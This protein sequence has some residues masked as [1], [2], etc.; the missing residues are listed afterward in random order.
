MQGAANAFKTGAVG[1]FM[2]Y[3]WNISEMKTARDQ[4]LNWG[5][6]L[7]PKSAT[8][9]KRSFYMHLECW[10][11]AK[12]S[13]VPNAAWQYIRDYTAEYTDDFVAFFPGIPM[14]KKDVGLF[15]TDETKGYG[16]DKLPD[17][18]SDP[19]NI[20][21]PGAGAKFDKISTL[22]QGEFDLAFT[23]SKSAKEACDAATP[24]V[25]EEL[26]RSTG[27]SAPDCDCRVTL[28]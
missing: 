24:L 26:A 3:A 11:A 17:I 13:K 14:L 20:R 16:W 1:M 18:I 23:G 15:I 10:A 4:G 9:G 8:T 5:C 22:V 12:V 21:I 27:F 25:D 19:A 28:P 7:P 6:V 2:G